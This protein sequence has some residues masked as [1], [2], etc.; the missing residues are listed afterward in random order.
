MSKV[1]YNL[2]IEVVEKSIE[3]L[4]PGTFMPR[5]QVT[6][7]CEFVTYVYIPDVVD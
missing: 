5:H 6:K 2:K 3:Q 4:P 1:I 7:V